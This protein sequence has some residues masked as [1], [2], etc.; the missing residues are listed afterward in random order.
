MKQ[1]QA[2][3][4][5]GEI[6]KG[7]VPTLADSSDRFLD[8]D[9]KQ[10]V[11]NLCNMW[12]SHIH[13]VMNEPSV[14][15]YR[16]VEHVRSKV[17]FIVE[18]KNLLKTKKVNEKIY[19][20]D[21]ALLACKSINSNT[22]WIFSESIRLLKNNFV[23][24]PLAPP[25]T[26]TTNKSKVFSFHKSNATSAQQQIETTTTLP[27]DVSV[28]ES[29]PSQNPTTNTVQSSTTSDDQQQQ[30]NPSEEN[31]PSV[32]T[33]S[34]VEILT[35]PSYEQSSAIDNSD[36]HASLNP[37]IKETTEPLSPPKKE[38][39]TQD[40]MTQTTQEQAHSDTTTT[41]TLTNSNEENIMTTTTTLTEASHPVVS[42]HGETQDES[43]VTEVTGI[44]SSMTTG[45]GDDEWSSL[46]I[47]PLPSSSTKKKKATK[48]KKK[49]QASEEEPAATEE[50]EALTPKTF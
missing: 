28:S 35:S 7:S 36:T 27:N 6:Y 18:Q 26:T 4:H 42:P 40:T 31:Q 24:V 49:Q 34:S 9:T 30:E 8:L 44:P 43:S 19:D 5:S 17:P 15:M 50:E 22:P 20:A 12:S 29:L 48:K 25:S 41:S 46:A 37:T 1:T 38:E 21:Y 3:T 45:G 2:P 10:S 39:S 16:I 14:G 32:D 11:V 23:S 33:K 13:H 47:Q